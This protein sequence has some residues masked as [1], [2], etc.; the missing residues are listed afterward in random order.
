METANMAKFWG[1]D[2]DV[3]DYEWSYIDYLDRR[4]YMFIHD[5]I[6]DRNTPDGDD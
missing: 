1:V 2:P 5:E 6:K 4:E 3:I